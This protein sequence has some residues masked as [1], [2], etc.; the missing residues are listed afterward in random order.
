MNE[1]LLPEL[2]EFQFPQLENCDKD[3]VSNTEFNKIV[4]PGKMFVII[5]EACDRENCQV[6]FSMLMAKKWLFM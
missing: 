5:N 4:H 6:M 3:N 1:S 2:S